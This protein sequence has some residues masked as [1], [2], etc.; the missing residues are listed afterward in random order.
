MDVNI[1]KTRNLAVWGFCTV[2][3]SL[4]SPGERSLILLDFVLLDFIIG[5]SW[6]CCLLGSP[7]LSQ[8]RSCQPVNLSGWLDSSCL[9]VWNSKS[10]RTEVLLF[11]TTF[12]GFTHQDFGTCSPYAANV[13]VRY[14]SH[15]VVPLSVHDP[16]LHRATIY[17]I[18]SRALLYSLQPVFIRKW[19]SFSKHL[20]SELNS[21]IF[22]ISVKSETSGKDVFSMCFV[23]I[24]KMI[25]IF[26]SK[27]MHNYK[28]CGWLI[29]WWCNE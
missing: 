28:S 13:A 8:L 29:A 17:W 27:K 24:F 23:L 16:S 12:D 5:S 14:P 3:C 7:H 10:Q 21:V 22:H 2:S 1:T 11:S 6:C 20:F 18:I 15:L 4:N 26:A 25:L 9:S 19:P